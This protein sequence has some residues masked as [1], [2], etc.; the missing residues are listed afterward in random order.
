MKYLKRILPIL[1]FVFSWSCALAQSNRGVPNLLKYDKKIIH[2]GF[3]LGYSQYDYIISTNP[4]LTT[5]PDCDSLRA[6]NTSSGPSFCLGIV[7]D[8]R[9]GKHFDLRF[10]PSLS[11]PSCRLNY[12]CSN[13]SIPDVSYAN[14][15]S[16]GMVF[17]D[18]PLMVKL[19]SSRMMNNVRAYVLAGAQYSYNLIQTKIDKLPTANETLLVNKQDVHAQV[20]VGF[21][22][23]CTY[24]KLATELKMSFGLIDQLQQEGK[25]VG[26]VN[27][28]KSK[29][30]QLSL[31]FE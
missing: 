5:I 25:Y 8:L 29:I 3:L 15:S 9:M 28:L 30:L 20:G 27:S 1:I 4:D 6:V 12:Y 16:A 21:D 31:T 2:F 13:S 22:F 24:F 26:S 7:T 18:L 19:K 11:F 23:Y 14:G 17:V 10:I